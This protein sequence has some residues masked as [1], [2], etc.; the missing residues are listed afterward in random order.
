[1]IVKQ[2]EGWNLTNNSDGYE[3]F[4]KKLFYWTGTVEDDR[5]KLAVKFEC[6][7]T[8]LKKNNSM[9]WWV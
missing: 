7:N 2:S 5:T 1:M 4:F 3:F 8:I 9:K 6:R